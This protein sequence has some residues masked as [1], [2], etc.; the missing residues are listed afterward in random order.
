MQP[1][2]NF[3]HGAPPR[4]VA[5]RHEN[6][7]LETLQE[8]SLLDLYIGQSDQRDHRPDTGLVQPQAVEK[9]STTTTTRFA[10]AAASC[11]SVAGRPIV[12]KLMLPR[13]EFLK[14]TGVAAAAQTTV[15]AANPPQYYCRQSEAIVRHL[16]MALVSPGTD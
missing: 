3:G 15:R 12:T 9:P 10:A 2:G 1:G 11:E 14:R 4:G 8:D 6:D 5:I 7:T 13:R 16:T